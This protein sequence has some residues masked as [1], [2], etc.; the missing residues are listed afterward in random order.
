MVNAG[1]STQPL[2]I[3]KPQKVWDLAFLDGTKQLTTT[4]VREHNFK[5]NDDVMLQNN[6]RLFCSTISAIKNWTLGYDRDILSNILL[7]ILLSFLYTYFIFNVLW[8]FLIAHKTEGF[9]YFFFY[10]LYSRKLH[11]HFNS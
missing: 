9:L 11:Y 8:C 4:F 10:K 1:S 3:L 2:E 6:F 7:H 5:K